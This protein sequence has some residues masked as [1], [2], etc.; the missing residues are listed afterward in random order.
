MALRSFRS[1]RGSA[2]PKQSHVLPEGR[3]Q[4]EVPS[5]DF[6]LGRRIVLWG[7]TGSGK[8]TLARRLGQTFGLGVVE[9]DAI[10]HANG[11]DTTDFDD[12]RAILTARLD[13]YERGGSQTAATT[14]SWTS[15]S[16]A[17]TR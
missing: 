13:G 14:K 7:V 9:L 12:F 2:E 5:K 10:R 4:N 1:L 17:P 11:W 16:P 3:A 6:D 8:T 15:T